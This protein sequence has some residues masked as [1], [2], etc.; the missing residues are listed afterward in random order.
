MHEDIELD[1]ATTHIQSKSSP[2]KK[3]IYIII[4]K[5]PVG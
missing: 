3:G 5:E 2:K 1:L 4:N